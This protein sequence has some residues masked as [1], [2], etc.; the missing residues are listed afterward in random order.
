MPK[1]S[2]SQQTQRRSHILDAA[3]RCFAA[4]GFHRTTM[5]DICKAA[6]VSAG[7]LY[8]YFDAKEAMIAGIAERDRTEV[9]E[10]FA[11][12]HESAGFIEGMQAVMI[13]CI[14]EQPAHKS[15]LYLAIAAEAVHNKAVARALA[16]C[17]AA[18]RASLTGILSRASAE[19][20]IAPA[21]PV[22]RIAAIM[23]LIADGMFWRR[24]VDPGCDLAIIA[25][26]LLSVI[27]Q[28]VGGPAAN[29]ARPQ[30]AEAA[31]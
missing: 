1:L 18:I 25:A 21:I 16:E 6:G 8:T 24:A 19:G 30:N 28:L 22:E 17:D 11:V 31:Q 9:I 29:A 7:A 26:D 15:Q 12:L 4:A 5:Q 20:R 2:V 23:S 14:L 10:K 27:S 13:S 3:E